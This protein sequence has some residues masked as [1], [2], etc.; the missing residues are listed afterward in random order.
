M[1]IDLLDLLNI[2]TFVIDIQNLKLNEQQSKELMGEL[3]QNQD[4]ML[5]QIILQNELIIKQNNKILE[6]LE[7][8][9]RP[10]R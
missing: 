3:R 8:A 1:N 2:I 6:V 10:V 9:V 4:N 5:K 7:N